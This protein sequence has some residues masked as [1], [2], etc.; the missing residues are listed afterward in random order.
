[1]TVYEFMRMLFNMVEESDYVMFVDSPDGKQ[2]YFINGIVVDEAK[3][4]V[5]ITTS[6]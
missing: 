4:Q 1:M 3:K 6:E 2:A 5:H